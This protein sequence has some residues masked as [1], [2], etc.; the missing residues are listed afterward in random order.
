MLWFDIEGSQYWSS[1]QAQNQAFFND[2]VAA[3]R[4]AGIAMGVYTSESQWTP[5]GGGGEM[6]RRTESNPG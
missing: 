6:E 1:S 4:A 2:M 5:V 3:G